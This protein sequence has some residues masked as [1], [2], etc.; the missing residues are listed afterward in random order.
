M[1]IL[2]SY[3]FIACGDDFFKSE[4]TIEIPDVESSLSVIANLNTTDNCHG[5]II[6][7]TQN[8]LSTEPFKI[9]RDATVKIEGLDQ[10]IFFSIN[11]MDSTY[12]ACDSF[13]ASQ[14]E[15][16]LT[17]E[18]EDILLTSSSTVPDKVDVTDVSLDFATDTT[19]VIDVID[20]ISF[21]ILDPP[22]DNYYKLEISYFEDFGPAFDLEESFYTIL[23]PESVTSSFELFTDEDF[24]NSTK[25]LRL[26]L[27]RCC[28]FNQE[29]IVKLRISLSNLSEDAYLYRKSILD[30]ES[31]NSNPLIDPTNI[32]SN[33]DGGLGIFSLSTAS[34]YEIPVE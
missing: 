32:Y 27:Q 23:N 4:T 9:I 30:Y 10:D 15:Y 13:V 29:N 24:E 5:L 11:D 20:L 34:I 12:Q 6:S 25:E 8:I 18:K 3:M 33:I 2:A 26:I 1:L 28:S 19:D 21:K 16:T 17:I 22:G 14:R 7:E 31:A